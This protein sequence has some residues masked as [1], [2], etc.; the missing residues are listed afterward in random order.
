MFNGLNCK[1]LDYKFLVFIKL[2]I[3]RKSFNWQNKTS[4]IVVCILQNISL[5]KFWVVSLT[6]TLVFISFL[7]WC[8]QKNLFLSMH[9]NT[10]CGPCYYLLPI[11]LRLKNSDPSFKP[12]RTGLCGAHWGILETTNVAHTCIIIL[13]LRKL[14]KYIYKYS[15]F[16][17][18]FVFYCQYVSEN[19]WRHWQF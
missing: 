12:T 8:F 17:P 10:A 9:E 7:G 19:R 15:R 2:F 3:E 18:S 1:F 5:R 11:H 13:S 14:K 4:W 16:L 6:H